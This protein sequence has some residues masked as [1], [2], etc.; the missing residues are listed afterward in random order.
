MEAASPPVQ[1]GDLRDHEKRRRPAG[2]GA[3]R[4]LRAGV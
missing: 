4:P 2:G 3:C 1:V